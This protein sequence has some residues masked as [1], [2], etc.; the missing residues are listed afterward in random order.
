MSARRDDVITVPR[1]SRVTSTKRQRFLNLIAN[2][3]GNHRNLKVVL[4][5]RFSCFRTTSHILPLLCTNRTVN[6]FNRALLEA[7]IAKSVHI[8]EDRQNELFQRKSTSNSQKTLTKAL[9]CWSKKV[10]K[11]AE[12]LIIQSTKAANLTHLASVSEAAR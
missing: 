12:A 2:S 10:S 7:A 5:K 8:A 4:T 3:G 11:F 9:N 6:Y 1:F